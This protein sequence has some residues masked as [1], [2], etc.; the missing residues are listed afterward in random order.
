MIIY[1]GTV[2]SDDPGI[3]NKDAAL[4]VSSQDK[5]RIEKNLVHLIFLLCYVVKKGT[6][7]P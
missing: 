2:S 6:T 1:A 5:E 7:S 3:V 4:D